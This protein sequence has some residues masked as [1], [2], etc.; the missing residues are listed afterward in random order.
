MLAIGGG[1]K[2]ILKDAFNYRRCGGSTQDKLHYV[3][4]YY[5]RSKEE[6][7]FKWSAKDYSKIIFG[8]EKIDMCSM[9]HVKN[10]MEINA[11]A[12]PGYLFKK[13]GYQSKAETL[14]VVWPIFEE[15]FTHWCTES[16]DDSPVPEELWTIASR[17]KLTK[18]ESAIEKAE[19][20]SPVGRAISMCSPLEQFIGFPLWKP[21]MDIIKAR[22]DCGV[23]PITI[24]IKKHG[25]SWKKLG[26][27]IERAKSVYCGDWSKFDQSVRKRL[28]EMSLDIIC[29]AFSKFFSPNTNYI[30]WFREYFNKNI[31]DK[32]YLVG[33]D[34]RVS[35]ENGVPSGSLWTSLI[36]SIVNYV[37]L[38]EVCLRELKT[39]YEIY[40]YGDDHLILMHDISDERRK[41]VKRRI[42]RTSERLFGLIPGKDDVYLCNGH[43]L[44]VGY[45]RP[46]YHPG[47]YLE[48]GTRDLEPERFEYSKTGFGDYNHAEGTTHRWNY[49]FSGRPKFLSFYW[50]KDLDPIRPLFDTINRMVNPEQPISSPIDNQVLILSHMLDNFHNDHVLNWGYHLLYDAQFH[51]GL[52]DKDYFHI[53]RT[54]SLWNRNSEY[55]RWYH[56]PGRAVKGERGWYRRIEAVYDLG[57]EDTMRVFNVRFRETIRRGIK[58]L[59]KA[60]RQGEVH[61]QKAQLV[62]NLAKG[63]MG[64]KLKRMVDKHYGDRKNISVIMESLSG[65]RKTFIIDQTRNEDFLRSLDFEARK[66]GRTTFFSAFTPRLLV[67]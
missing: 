30:S 64:T 54:K 11:T 31:I 17:P 27:K 44:R 28:L 12:N 52:C 26:K 36:D 53:D 63:F 48:K 45:K 59:M 67:G 56:D 10:E 8:E 40:V 7:D 41:T 14:G 1:A 57:N 60:E 15:L 23:C 29:A 21:L 49:A 6:I 9:E 55:W 18:V 43:S 24:G 58:A 46:V 39:T 33:K 34:L 47:N 22:N 32:T 38:N 42:M 66:L 61:N 50:N 37:V 2:A 4:T 5:E 3:S 20:G 51:I 25:D 62:K 19:T 16:Y 13:N 35:V 65:F